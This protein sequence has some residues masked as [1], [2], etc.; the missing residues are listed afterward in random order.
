MSHISV[1]KHRIV[2]LDVFAEACAELGHTFQILSEG[3]TV[4]MY[5]RQ[6]AS[7]VAFFKL[8]D[9]RYPLTID[10]DGYISYDNW[11]SKSTSMGT[12][13]KVLQTYNEK[14]IKAAIDYTQY[15]QV[16][17]VMNENGDIEI[18]VIN[19]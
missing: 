19:Y 1:Y 16:T 7:G 5:G 17:T 3:E 18:E 6:T 2:D 11:G 4:Q 10:K 8:D 14:K 15:D 9:W 12:L 13:G